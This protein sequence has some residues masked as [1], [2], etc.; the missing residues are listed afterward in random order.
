MRIL[1][2]YEANQ[3]IHKD[4]IFFITH[5]GFIMMMVTEAMEQVRQY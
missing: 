4:K 2:I 3:Q 5:S 1:H